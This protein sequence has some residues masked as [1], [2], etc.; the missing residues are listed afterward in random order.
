MGKNAKLKERQKWS[1]EKP[2]LDNARKLRGIYFIDPEDKEFKETIKNARKKLETPVAPAMPCKISKNNQ[3][4]GIVV[5]PMRS[6]SKLACILEASESTRLR[7]GESRYRIIMK[8]ILQEKE[9]IHYSITIW[10][11]NLFLMPQAM[12]IPAAKAAVDKEWEKLEKISAWNLTKVRSKKEVIDEARTSGAKVHFA[13]LMDICHL[14]NAELEAKHQKYKGR[15]V[16]R[17]DIVKDDSGSYAVFTEQG[18]SAS[19]M[20]AA[21]VMDIISRLPGCAGQAADA[22]S[23]Y[24]QVKME[25]APKLLKIPKSECPDIWIRLPRH[26]WPKSWSSMEDPVVPLERNLYGHPLAGLLWERQFEKILL[27]HGWEKV[28]NWECLF[29]HREKGLFLSVYVDDIKLA[30]KKQNIDPM[31]KVLNKEVDLGEP[32]SF[33]DHV[34]LGCTQR[35]CEISKDIV[36]NYRTMFESRISAERN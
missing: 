13:S 28:S 33:L 5:N 14:K 8:T 10:F 20:T 1:H 19:Q 9:T 30:G 34:Y 26:K 32:T 16:L 21:K 27:K 31:W 12:K 4:W 36:D 22:V 24:T 15:V 23:A 2:Q 6:K 17:G 7:M 29:V 11:T 18:S 3:N 25:D 35:Q